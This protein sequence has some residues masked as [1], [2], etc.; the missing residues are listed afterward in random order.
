MIFELGDTT[1]VCDELEDLVGGIGHHLIGLFF[2]A[3]VVVL[4][5]G[6]S[7]LARS[8]RAAAVHEAAERFGLDD[9]LI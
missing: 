9:E 4:F 1:F 5:Q 7:E 3:P 2:T 6:E 8:N